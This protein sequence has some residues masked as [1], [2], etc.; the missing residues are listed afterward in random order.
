MTPEG[1]NLGDSRGKYHFSTRPPGNVY[2]E[3]S[4]NGESITKKDGGQGRIRT[5]VARKERQIYSLLPLT[6]RPPVRV[7]EGR[8]IAALGA[9]A[10]D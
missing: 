10:S 9:Q 4:V 8:W 7:R 6:T 2:L 1:E 5:S 3:D